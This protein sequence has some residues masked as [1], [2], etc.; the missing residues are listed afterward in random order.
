VVKELD[1]AAQ[2][3]AVEL[4][5]EYGDVAVVRLEADDT[6]EESSETDTQQPAHRMVVL[7]RTEEKWLVRDVY[8]VAD[9]P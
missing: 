8:D 7:I 3:S 4:V 9:Q 5:D 2:E 1:A 6:G